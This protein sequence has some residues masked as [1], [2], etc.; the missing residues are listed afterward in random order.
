MDRWTRHVQTAHM[1]IALLQT[2]MA[3]EQRRPVED[4]WPVD[5]VTH[6]DLP[7]AQRARSFTARARG[8]TPLRRS[9]SGTSSARGS[10]PRLS[11]PRVTY[12]LSAP[13]RAQSASGR[14]GA[15]GLALCFCAPWSIDDGGSLA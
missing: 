11:A 8:S 9:K 10:G 13:S 7:S 5:S 2:K 4:R 15:W 3:D 12:C 14:D 6:H 1:A